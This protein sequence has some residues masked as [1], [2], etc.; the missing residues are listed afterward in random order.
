[1]LCLVLQVYLTLCGPMDCGPPDFSVHGDSPGMNLGEWVA[2]PYSRVFSQPRDQTQVSLIAGG[3]FTNWATREAV[4]Y[5]YTHIY[6]HT[7][8]YIYMHT[9][10]L[11]LHIYMYTYMYI[12]LD[13]HR[14]LWKK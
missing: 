7:H 9:Y 13:S 10:T 4:I 14:H 6:T 2:M 12:L 5:V 11:Y 3:F 1:M 8:T